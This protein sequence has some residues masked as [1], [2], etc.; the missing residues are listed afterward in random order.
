MECMF[1]LFASSRDDAMVDGMYVLHLTSSKDDVRNG[2]FCS[3][4]LSDD[5]ECSAAHIIDG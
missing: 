1:L 4:V 2:F 5:S 3:I